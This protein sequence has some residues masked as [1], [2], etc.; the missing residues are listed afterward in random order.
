MACGNSGAGKPHDQV[1]VRGLDTYKDEKPS[2]KKSETIPAAG[3]VLPQAWVK[4]SLL[5]HCIADRG[6]LDE[7][8]SVILVQL[9]EKHGINGRLVTYDAVSREKIETLDTTNLEIV[10]ISFLDIGGS[11]AH[12]RYLIQRVRRRLPQGAQIIVGI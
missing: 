12:L 9:L 2:P 1:L 6:P 3:S 5:V 11:P 8:T 10:C 7:T 4:K